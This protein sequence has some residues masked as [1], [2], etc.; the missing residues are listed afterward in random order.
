MIEKIIAIFRKNNFNICIG[1][2][3]ENLPLITANFYFTNSIKK[4]PNK[5]FIGLPT[6]TI[7]R[8]MFAVRLL[9]E[10]KKTEV[11]IFDGEYVLILLKRNNDIYVYYQWKYLINKIND[12]FI[13]MNRRSEKMKLFYRG[14]YL[15]FVKKVYKISLDV[16][17]KFEKYGIRSDAEIELYQ[18]IPVLEKYIKKIEK[19]Q[20]SDKI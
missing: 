16:K 5:N 8:L 13:E 10:N 11:R 19:L 6:T 15:D 7:R 4:I 17:E 2:V 14:E 9:K 12:N 20:K 3:Y 18:Q 1:K